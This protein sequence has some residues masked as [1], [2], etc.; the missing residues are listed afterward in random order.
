MRK[1]EFYPVWLITIY[2]GEVA[3]NHTLAGEIWLLERRIRVRSRGILPERPS[4][5]Q[6]YREDI[7]D[8]ED[9]MLEMAY[10]QDPQNVWSD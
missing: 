5:R 1:S 4:S 9:G 2:T 3:R 7:F 6:H 8:H 10:R